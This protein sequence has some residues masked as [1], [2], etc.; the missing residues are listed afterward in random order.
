MLKGQ[1]IPVTFAAPK[2]CYRGWHGVMC[3]SSATIGRVKDAAYDYMNWWLSGWPGAFIVRQGYYISNPQR[4]AQYLD[5][6]EWDHWYDGK[7]AKKYRRKIQYLRGSC[8]RGAAT[9]NA[10]VTLQCGIPRCLPMIIACK[11][12]MNL[13]VH[14]W[15]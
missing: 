15:Y 10:L 4:S 7:G 14:D 9:T 1:G 6:A 5:Q 13:S 8:E 2:E 12:G 11:N 3:L